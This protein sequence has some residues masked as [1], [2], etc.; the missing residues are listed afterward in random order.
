[1]YLI[2]KM[3]AIQSQKKA[4]IMYRNIQFRIG[5]IYS[6]SCSH[7][8]MTVHV[9]VPHKMVLIFRFKG[10]GDVVFNSMNEHNNT[11]NIPF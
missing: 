3:N 10:D 5:K 1:M 4:R 7:I 6:I 11:Q 9:H 8:L 2:I